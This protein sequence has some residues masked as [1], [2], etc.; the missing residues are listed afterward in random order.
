MADLKDAIGLK[1]YRKKMINE[2]D[3]E[4]IGGAIKKGAKKL[5]GREDEGFLKKAGK[6]LVGAARAITGT[7][8]P[9]TAGEHFK[10]AGSMAVKAGKKVAEEH[11]FATKAGAGAAGVT[12][13]AL[14]LRKLKKK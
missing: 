12:A 5:I 11:P 3:L 6:R 14:A 9:M 1:L 10:R 2:L 13:G 8:K 4:D 7:E